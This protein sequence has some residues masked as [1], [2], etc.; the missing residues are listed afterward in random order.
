MNS[1]RKCL[2]L[3]GVLSFSSS[4]LAQEGAEAEAEEAAV[5]E[6]PDIPYTVGEQ[7]E[8]VELSA[9][10]GGS[11][12]NELVKLPNLRA[13]GGQKTV[14]SAFAGMRQQAMNAVMRVYGC[15]I[16]EELAKQAPDDLD[17]QV[18]QL[19][20]GLTSLRLQM[21]I[22]AGW[23]DFSASEKFE[24][25]E[26]IGART[27]RESDAGT[28]DPAILDAAIGGLRTDE[29]F[30]SVVT[31]QR[32]LGLDFAGV[33]D[34]QGCET[35]VRAAISD[36]SSSLQRSLADVQQILLNHLDAGVAPNVAL[37]ELALTMADNP[38]GQTTVSNAALTSCTQTAESSDINL[39]EITA[40]ID[41][42]A[43][44]DV[45]DETGSETENSE[46]E[47]EG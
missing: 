8:S 25:S 37:S 20:A 2:I 44:A 11:A 5:S 12:L 33:I 29:L 4:A 34:V 7:V 38:A 23:A 17:E 35:I 21:A 36:G 30:I 40:L 27:T 31:R 3:F 41:L 1:L 26:R 14:R 15:M 16:A 9:R 18:M 42:D 32:W 22:L 43:N 19:N 6:C 24:I 28:I 46:I 39:N 10:F 47:N 45:D 13:Y